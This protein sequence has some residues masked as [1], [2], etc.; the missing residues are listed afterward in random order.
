MIGND[1]R[2]DMQA[3]SSVGMDCYLVT[4]CMILAEDFE[5]SGPTGTFKELIEYLKA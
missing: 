3:A 5:W 2:E 4:D 1:V